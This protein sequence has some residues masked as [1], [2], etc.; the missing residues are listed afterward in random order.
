VGVTFKPNERSALYLRGGR[1]SAYPLLIETA[2]AFG[3]QSLRSP[4]TWQGVA[5]GQWGIGDFEFKTEAYAIRFADQ[6]LMTPDGRSFTNAGDGTSYGAEFYVKKALGKTGTIAWFNYAFNKADRSFFDGTNLVWSRFRREVPHSLSL[7][8]AQG[9][10][11]RKKSKLI[12]GSRLAFSVGR[13]YTGQTVQRDATSGGL[14][15]TEDS[16]KFQERLPNRFTWDLKISWDFP[17][18][19]SGEASLYLDF[20]SVEGIFGLKNATYAFFDAG[21]VNPA[22]AKLYD[23]SLKVGDK[24][25][26]MFMHDIPPM[27]ILGFKLTF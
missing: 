11:L 26:V 19:K 16:H 12:V 10:P 17:V 1:Y 27:P 3:G 22:N 5:G 7:I 18:F 14:V 6:I 20:W 2:P 25:P 13:A 15:F 24:A 9:I 21:M 8:V 4:Y 23:P